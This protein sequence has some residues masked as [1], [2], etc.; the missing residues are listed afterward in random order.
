MLHA[1]AVLTLHTFF[2]CFGPGRR[3]HE[4]PAAGTALP[5]AIVNCSQRPANPERAADGAFPQAPCQPPRELVASLQSVQDV[6]RELPVEADRLSIRSS[7]S[8]TPPGMESDFTPLTP[9]TASTPRRID[10]LIE[11]AALSRLQHAMAAVVGADGSSVSCRDP[12]A[13]SQGRGT[14]PAA[15]YPLRPQAVFRLRSAAPFS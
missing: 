3:T 9:S 5:T 7:D 11:A 12:E 1:N 14:A 10:V 2:R 8:S 15:H 13:D 6:T 4:T